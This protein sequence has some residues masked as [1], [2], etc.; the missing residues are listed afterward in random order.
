[1]HNTLLIHWEQK[2]SILNTVLLIISSSITFQQNPITHEK[3]RIEYRSSEWI[4]LEEVETNYCED[5]HAETKVY[6]VESSEAQ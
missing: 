4:T 5:E 1:M 3:E 2:R 6:F